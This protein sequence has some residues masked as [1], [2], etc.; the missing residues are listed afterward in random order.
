MYY[1]PVLGRVYLEGKNIEEANDTLQTLL[2]EY[3]RQPN[4]IVSFVLKKIAVLGEVRSPGYFT[5]TNSSIN[6]FQ[7][8]GMAGDITIL[9]NKRTV[10]VIRT[11]ESRITKHYVDLTKDS[12][13]QSDYYFLEPK[14]VVFVAPAKARQWSISSIPYELV[15]TSITTLILLLNYFN[16]N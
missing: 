2:S 16:H 11:N 12:I 6:I 10:L 13:F 1:F 5:Y 9:G 4:V 7:A 14:D 3:F 15:I 8:L